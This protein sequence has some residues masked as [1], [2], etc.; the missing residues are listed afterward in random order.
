MRFVFRMLRAIGTRFFCR[1]SI[2][3][4]KFADRLGGPCEITVP[5]CESHW[6]AFMEVVGTDDVNQKELIIL[7]Y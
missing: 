6:R 2:R 5:Q 1:Y 3:L 7:H 4:S